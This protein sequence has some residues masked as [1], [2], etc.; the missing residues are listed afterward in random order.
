MSSLHQTILKLREMELVMENIQPL[1]EEEVAVGAGSGADAD[2]DGGIMS[3]GEGAG[4]R[5]EDTLEIVF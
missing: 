3:L 1:D 4:T 2:Q 5:D